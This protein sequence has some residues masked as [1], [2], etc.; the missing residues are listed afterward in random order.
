MTRQNVWVKKL[1]RQGW[2]DGCFKIS[3]M[4]TEWVH[5]ECLL[6]CGKPPHGQVTEFNLGLGQSDRERSTNI[7]ALIHRL[8]VI[9]NGKKPELHYN[10]GIRLCQNTGRGI[11]N[12]IRCQLSWYQTQEKQ[13]KNVI[14]LCEYQ[15]LAWCQ[16][17][18]QDHHNWWPKCSLGPRKVSISRESQ[19]LCMWANHGSVR[20]GI[21]QQGQRLV[22]WCWRDE[23]S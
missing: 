11:L 14:E 19:H 21:G 15:T 18:F 12:P 4:H 6:M 5:H 13:Q 17:D 22:K 20:R 7:H 2:I 9:V 8:C 16:Q 23:H 10:S 3:A 1:Q